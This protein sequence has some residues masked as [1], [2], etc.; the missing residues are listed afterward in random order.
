MN[1]DQAV[2]S[3]RE[4]KLPMGWVSTTT[5]SEIDKNLGPD[6]ILK[7][8]RTKEKIK[9]SEIDKKS[10]ILLSHSPYMLEINLNNHCDMSCLYCGPHFSSTWL[11]KNTEIWAERVGQKNF[12]ENDHQRLRINSSVVPRRISKSPFG[13]GLKKY[14]L[15]PYLG[16]ASAS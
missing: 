11:N 6:T 3:A 1:E 13:L 10:S 8:V 12:D 16:S 4:F 9:I 14:S 7:N 2:Q 5:N 15:P